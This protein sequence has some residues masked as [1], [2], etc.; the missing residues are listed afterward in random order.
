MCLASYPNRRRPRSVDGQ[1]IDDEGRRRGRLVGKKRELPD[2]FPLLDL[3]QTVFQDPELIL[4]E[5]DQA[6]QAW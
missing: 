6:L 5:S 1:E 3:T 2:R 4:R